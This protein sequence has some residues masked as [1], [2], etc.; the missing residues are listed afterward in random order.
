[1]ASSEDLVPKGLPHGERQRIEAGMQ[2]ANLP[3]GSSGGGG[4]IPVPPTRSGPPRSTNAAAPTD[5]LM[6]LD[7]SM[8]SPVQ[9]PATFEQKIEAIA[10]RTANPFLRLAAGRILAKR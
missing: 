3:L 6:T 7:A 8:F 9:A 2:Q 1:M 10:Q 4:R 5:P